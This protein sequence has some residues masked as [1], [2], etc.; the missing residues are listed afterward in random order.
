M[1]WELHVA[2][3]ARSKGTESFLCGDLDVLA[4]L[5]T[6]NREAARRLHPGTVSSRMDELFAAGADARTPLPDAAASIPVS[7]R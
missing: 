3:I 2:R 1:R 7:S 4:G 5:L 6:V